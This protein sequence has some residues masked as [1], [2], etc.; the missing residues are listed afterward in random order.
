MSGQHCG[1]PVLFP[2]GQRELLQQGQSHSLPA[3]TQLKGFPPPVEGPHSSGILCSMVKE[4]V[5]LFIGLVLGPGLPAFWVAR[6][7]GLASIYL[8]SEGSAGAG[9][10]SG[11][12]YYLWLNKAYSNLVKRCWSGYMH[13]LTSRGSARAS[14]GTGNWSSLLLGRKSTE[15]LTSEDPTSSGISG[16]LCMNMWERD[17]QMHVSEPPAQTWM[18]K[19]HY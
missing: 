12:W 4:V 3:G 17:E 8:T 16:K 13:G 19:L 15:M 11:N 5:V 6:E 7:G 14:L 1:F 10:G 18:L 9:F 2:L